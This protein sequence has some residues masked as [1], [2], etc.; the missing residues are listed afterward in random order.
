[1]ARNVDLALAAGVGAIVWLW[2]PY[3]TPTR[4]KLLKGFQ[5]QIGDPLA[6]ALN[7]PATVPQPPANSTPAAPAATKPVASAPITTQPDTAVYHAFRV[8]L[9]TTSLNQQIW[10]HHQNDGHWEYVDS[11]AQFGR[12]GIAA[13]MNNVTDIVWGSARAFAV[14]EGSRTPVPVDREADWLWSSTP[15]GVP[16]VYPN[17]PSDLTSALRSGIR[18]GALVPAGPVGYAILKQQGIS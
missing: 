4:Q 5:D 11:P 7:P 1:M 16:D 17:V 6:G 2:S 13:D 18:S 10:V 9:P 3:G 14:G 8:R 15:T 12:F